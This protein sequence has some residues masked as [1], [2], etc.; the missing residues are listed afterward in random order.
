[1]TSDVFGLYSLTYQPTQKSDVIYEC[2][3]GETLPDQQLKIVSDH[4]FSDQQ[5]LTASETVFCLKFSQF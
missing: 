1:M 5:I 3:L 2:S 4:F